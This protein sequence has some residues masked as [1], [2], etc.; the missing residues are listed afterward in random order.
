MPNIKYAYA[1]EEFREASFIEGENL[2]TVLK[3]ENVKIFA[4]CGG[5]GHCKKCR[6]LLNGEEMTA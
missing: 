2:L 3:R 4:P 5:H 6:V 1:G